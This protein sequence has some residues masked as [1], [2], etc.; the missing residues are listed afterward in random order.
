MD[1]QSL[2]TFVA[3]TEE[4]GILAASRHLDTVQSNV[5]AR[6]QR[7]ERE[8]GTE[9]FYRQGRGLTLAPSGRVLLGYARQILELESQAGQAVRQVGGQSGE[10]R[11]GAMETFAALRLPAMLGQL[12]EAHPLLS[13]RVQT[14]TSQVL[15]RQL[16]D[17]EIDCALVGGP[18]DHPDLVATEVAA[19]E[20]VLVLARND[21]SNSAPL[22]LFREGCAYRARALA[23]QRSLGHQV[24]EVMEFGTLDGILGC[25]AAGLGR[26]LMP[27]R[28][29]DNSHYQPQLRVQPIDPALAKVPTVLIRHR[30]ALPMPALDTLRDAIQAHRLAA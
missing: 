18:V 19:E 29:V 2:R 14:E 23:W 26:T 7:L 24:D 22:I 20:L 17:H 11:I 30:Q 10:L 1:L 28:V 27:R 15:T 9:L 21:E 13:I 25:V 6:I 12:R 4:G 16:I 3:V 8:L 5:T